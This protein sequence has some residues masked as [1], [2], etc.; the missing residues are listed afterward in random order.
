MGTVRKTTVRQ[1]GCRI[2]AGHG[3]CQVISQLSRSFHSFL[4]NSVISSK[5]TYLEAVKPVHRSDKSAY[6]QLF[7]Q[8]FSVAD[9]C[10]SVNLA[11]C[12][13]IC[14]NK[15]ACEMTPQAVLF[16]VY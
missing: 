10:I 1:N 5:I 11:F 6:C 12:R 15:T 4:R 16:D 9:N 2:G 3:H 8:F 14:Y 13:L 7:R